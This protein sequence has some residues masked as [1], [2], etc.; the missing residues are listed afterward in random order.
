MMTS[1]GSSCS[2]AIIYTARVS[3]MLMVCV[4]IHIQAQVPFGTAPAPNALLERE[5]LLPIS[6]EWLKP[7]F[8][9]T[10]ELS[11]AEGFRTGP[12]PPTSAH[13]GHRFFRYHPYHII[14]ST[15]KVLPMYP[16]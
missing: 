3:N 15:S 1:I 11:R 14:F 10:G 13:Q 7:S 9:S 4:M 12:Q 5:E 8:T 2:D 6:K 16:H